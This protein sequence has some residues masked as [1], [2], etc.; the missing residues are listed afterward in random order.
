MESEN[1]LAEVRYTLD[2]GEP[3]PDSPVFEKPFP[4]TGA[5][6]VRAASFLDGERVSYIRSTEIVEGT[7]VEDY[8]P[9]TYYPS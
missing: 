1:P 9:L 4:V 3:A 8:Y 5:V 7:D 2:G 6:T